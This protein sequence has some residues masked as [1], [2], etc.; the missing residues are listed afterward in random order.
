MVRTGCRAS[1]EPGQPDMSSA[2]E[3]KFEAWVPDYGCRGFAIRELHVARISGAASEAHA[4]RYGKNEVSQQSH[5]SFRWT[6]DSS[7]RSTYCD[8]HGNRV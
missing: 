3:S 7:G 6:P 5:H 4:R 1:L 2:T 8:I